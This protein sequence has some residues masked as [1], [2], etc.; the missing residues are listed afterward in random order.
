[1]KKL[2]SVTMIIAAVALLGASGS[3]Q[4]TQTSDR[5]ES[6]FKNSFVYITYLRDDA[7]K[8]QSTND[9][10][11]ALTG[12]VSEWF[13]SSLA[14]ETV[15][16]LPGV[17]RVDN[18]LEVKGGRPADNSDAWIGMKVKTMLMFHSN[19]SSLKTDVDVISGVVTLHGQASSETQKEL[20][21][22]Y[23]KDVKGV[24]SVKNDMTVGKIKKTTG[25]KVSEYIDDASITAQVK[26]A[27]LFHLS[28]SVVS[29]K[30]DTKNG[31]V[32]V[33][34]VAKNSVEKD[35]VGK[36]VTNIKGVKSLKNKMTIG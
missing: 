23:V 35:L 4:A 6:S 34:G 8:I 1:M 25:E 9:S 32:T 2:N 20:T 17:M 7:I 14:E 10:V 12:T 3:L 21:T 16:G 5:I 36:L 30:V 31:I 15:A 18:K 22:E 13:H 29:T 11:V 24:Q 19:V 27:L 28:T 33:S 26:L